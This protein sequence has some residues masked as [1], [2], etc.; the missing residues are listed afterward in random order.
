VPLHR[1]RQFS[2]SFNQAG[3]IAQRL[4]KRLDIPVDVGLL[5]RMRRTQAQSGLDKPERKRNIRG[6]FK[7]KPIKAT[8]IALVDDVLTTGTTLAECSREARRAGALKVSVWVAARA[9]LGRA[10]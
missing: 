3:Y 8:H 1:L 5:K 6:A 2:R 9:N 10:L 4:G 7:C